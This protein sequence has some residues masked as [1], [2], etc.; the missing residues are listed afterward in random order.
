[1]VL[2]VGT[3]LFFT[4]RQKSLK[5]YLL[6]DQD[7]HWIIVA[8]SVLAALFSGIT[9]LGAPAEAYYHDLCYI[10]VLASFFIATPITTLVFL[11]F[12]RGLNLFTAYE[13]L[14]RR[15][16]LRVRRIAS[17]LFI[18]RVTFYM[19]MV[20]YAPGPGD[21]GDHGL[22]VV[23]LGLAHRRG[24]DPVHD[25]RGHEG[26]HLDGFAPVPR[27]LRRHPADPG[28][29]HRRGPGRFRDGLGPGGQGGPHAIPE[30]QTSIR[31]CA[32]PSGA[33]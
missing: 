30:L 31:P 10:W 17:A 33:R 5:S 29:R 12:F 8:I 27:P 32:S 20:I 22:A 21:H 3:G 14:D 1:M 13:Y 19:A 4:R 23:D 2:L 26:R 15:F 25:V 9:Y 7:I 18:A 28:L 24:G 16:D 11:P 6:A